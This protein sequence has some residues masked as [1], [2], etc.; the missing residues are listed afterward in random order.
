MEK[1]TLSKIA[2]ITG[3]SRGLGLAT[4]REFA[5]QG[6]QVVGT[7]RSERPTELPKDVEYHQFDA[8]NAADCETFWRQ[9]GSEHPGAEICLVNNAGGYITG[10]LTELKPE[11]YEQQM[12]SCYFSSVFMTRGLALT[13]SKG[14]IVNIIS[15]GA[16]RAH[17]NDSAYSPA[18]AA[19][20]HFFHALQDEL[21]GAQYQITNL[22]PRYIGPDEGSTKPEDLAKFV[23]EQAENERT[24][25]LADV[26]VLPS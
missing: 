8:G 19:Q 11:D 26:T 10:G 2:V 12:R 22:Y 24:Y 21:D 5:A 15:T 25:Y 9:L 13:F 4:A 17:K 18:K 7:G 14:K 3:V 1:E 23:R 16:L 20:M 6:W